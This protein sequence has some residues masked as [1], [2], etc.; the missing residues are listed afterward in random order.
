M[1]KKF[2]V[3]VILLALTIGAAYVWGAFTQL[4]TGGR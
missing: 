2:W 1:S 4:S 3:V